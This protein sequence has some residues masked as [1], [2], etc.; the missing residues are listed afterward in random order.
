MSTKIFE[1]YFKYSSDQYPTAIKD[2]EIA[3]LL[4]FVTLTDETQRDAFAAAFE[5]HLIRAVGCAI[6]VKINPCCF[7]LEGKPNIGKT[8]FINFLCPPI[9][10]YSLLNISEKDI[11]TYDPDLYRYFIINIDGYFKGTEVARI[12]ER[13]NIA[14]LKVREPFLDNKTKIIRRTASF[15]GTTYEHEINRNETSFVVFKI[16]KINYNYSTE[17]NIDKVWAQAA[18]LWEKQ[19]L[20][21]Q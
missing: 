20:S 2:N 13:L 6:G 17:V 8:T 16:D 9:V 1:K 19:L 3:K 21:N 5:N 10:E 18:Q 4:S 15:F 7:V 14:T 12:K 11:L